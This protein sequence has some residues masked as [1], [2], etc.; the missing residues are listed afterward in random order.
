M[1]RFKGFLKQHKEGL[2]NLILVLVMILS[3]F[4]ILRSLG[5]VHFKAPDFAQIQRAVEAS[6][7][8]QTM[9]S[10]DEAALRKNYGINA[11]DLEAF[12][13]YAPRS[14]MDASEILILQAKNESSLGSWRSVID[15][16]R[17]TRADMYRNYR[18]E[19]ALLLEDSQ[20]K[21]QGNFLIFISARNVSEVQA[22]VEQ[23]FR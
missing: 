6:A 19:E 10:G 21:V 23:S 2:R 9:V 18:P 4:V 16:R 14:A 12:I 1:S 11:R 20:L 22:A 15:A 8:P 3:T 5:I 17:S 7:D 13:Y